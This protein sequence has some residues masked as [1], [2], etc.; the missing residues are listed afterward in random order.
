VIDFL[1]S[2]GHVDPL[3][4]GGREIGD[5]TMAVAKQRPANNNNNKGRLLS[6]DTGEVQSPK[7]CLK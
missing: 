2:I 4:D 5:C 3:L 6:E 1:N 7:C